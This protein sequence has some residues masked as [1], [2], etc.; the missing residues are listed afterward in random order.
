VELEANS[1]ELKKFIK[2]KNHR[3]LEFSPNKP[4]YGRKAKQVCKPVALPG[5]SLVFKVM[6]QSL[7][8]L[9]ALV[10]F[11]EGSVEEPL[12]CVIS[13]HRHVGLLVFNP[14]SPLQQS[15]GGFTSA[16]VTYE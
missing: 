1:P 2:K 9:K 7:G 15:P 6:A 4:L 13:W 8:R 5:Q 3:V 14:L 12:S 10:M 11:T 16:P